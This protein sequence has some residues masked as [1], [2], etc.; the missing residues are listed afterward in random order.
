MNELI[1]RAHIE[2]EQIVHVG[3]GGGGGGAFFRYFKTIMIK[4]LKQ[5]C[6]RVQKIYN[7]KQ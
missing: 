2:T 7:D 6:T 4:R 3:G 1:H 5:I